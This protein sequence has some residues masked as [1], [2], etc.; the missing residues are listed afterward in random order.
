M[1]KIFRIDDVCSNTNMEKLIKMIYLIQHY[2]PES[3]T[4]IALSIFYFDC[5][6]ERVHPPIFTPMSDNRNYYKTTKISDINKIK[7][8]ISRHPDIKFPENIKYAAHGIPHSDHRLMS[9]TAQE[10]SIIMS[11]SV[12]DSEIFVPPYNKW[13]KKTEKICQKN[14]ILLIKFEDGWRHLLHNPVNN[15]INLYYFHTFDF[16]DLNEFEKKLKQ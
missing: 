15:K 11:C 5:V 13:N 12:C 3:E 8:D 16:K 4:L 10:L 2:H 6:D 7:S 1:R 14:G 9:K